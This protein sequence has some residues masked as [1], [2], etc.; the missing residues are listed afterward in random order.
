[1]C[2]ISYDMALFL[3]LI[4]RKIDLTVVLKIFVVKKLRY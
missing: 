2:H 4:T 1:M 3:G